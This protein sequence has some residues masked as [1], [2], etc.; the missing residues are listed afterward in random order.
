[1]F[2]VAGRPPARF[3]ELPWTTARIQESATED[4]VYATLE[5]VTLDPVDS[6]PSDPLLRQLTTELASSTDGYWYRIV[7]G[8]ASGELADPTL[9]V[10]NSTA[11]VTAL[12][13]VATT[14]ELARILKVRTPSAGQTAA[15]TRVL[16]TAA[17][18]VA[19][20]I[21]DTDAALAGWQLSLGAEVVL[22]RAVEHWRQME[23]PFGLVGLG[24]ELPAERTARDSWERHA[25]KLAP[26]KQSWGL[27]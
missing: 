8:D 13:A 25:H 6:D 14:S 10:Q 4:G 9:P 23:S 3:D 20:E 5:T 17:G 19:S 16:E 11:T 15:M 27:A 22:E 2:T 21:G 7:F 18:E 1:M 12:L 26:L 24:P